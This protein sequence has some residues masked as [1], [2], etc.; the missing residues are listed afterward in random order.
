MMECT[1]KLGG[2]TACSGGVIWMRDNPY[3]AEERIADSREEGFMYLRGISAASHE[4]WSEWPHRTSYSRSYGWR[5]GIPR[6]GHV[7]C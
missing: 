7:A 3:I 2:G 1:D 6:L 4:D 5:S